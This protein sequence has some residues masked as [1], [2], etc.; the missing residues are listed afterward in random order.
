MNLL[1]G[2][3]FDSWSEFVDMG[4]YGFNVWAV[5]ALFAVFIVINLFSPLL[6]RRH[7]LRDL[8][9]RRSLGQRDPANDPSARPQGSHKLEEAEVDS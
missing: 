6:Q 1:A 8:K 4:G 9:R 3:Q 5:Y 7:I 2:I